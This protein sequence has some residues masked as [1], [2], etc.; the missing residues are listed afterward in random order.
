VSTRPVSKAVFE[1]KPPTKAASPC[2]AAFKI[3]LTALSTR[4]W[5]VLLT[6]EVC[7]VA[8]LWTNADL[9]VPVRCMWH[10][11]FVV[12]A[13]LRKDRH[14]E[15]QLSIEQLP[16]AVSAVLETERFIRKRF[17]Q[18][19]ARVERTR[20]SNKEHTLDTRKFVPTHCVM[21]E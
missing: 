19:A 12:P 11:S 7:Y 16:N 5:N 20:L 8:A 2:A 1:R 13:D 17:G 4:S 6:D 15:L 18:L 3:V 10:S 9:N 14:A 21:K